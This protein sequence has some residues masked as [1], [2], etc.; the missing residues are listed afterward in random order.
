VASAERWS[1]SAKYLTQAFRSRQAHLEM[2]FACCEN[3]VFSCLLD[4]S[5]H[6]WISLIEHPETFHELGHLG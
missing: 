3:D 4:Q 1:Q 5:L 2:E 6:A